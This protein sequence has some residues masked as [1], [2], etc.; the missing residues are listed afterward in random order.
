MYKPLDCIALRTVRYS[1]RNSILTAYT[2]QAGR[3]SLLIPSGGGRVA[4][5]L[6]ALLMPLG[7]FE[8]VADI[9]PN[10]EIHPIRDVKSMVPPPVA[11]PARATIALFIADFL[12]GLLKEQMSDPLLFSFI[13]SA[14]RRLADDR[15]GY[16]LQ[17]LSLLNF[18]I[19][20]LTRLTRFVGI[21]PD[22][23]THTPGSFLDL[24]DGVFRPMPPPHRNYLPAG[25][26]AAAAWLGRI[27]FRNLG[28]FKL[29]RL[30]RNIATDRILTYYRTHYPSSAGESALAILRMLA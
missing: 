14:L 7:R 18:H 28:L 29:D 5:R 24:E 3:L 27:N 2:R 19:C 21:E 30:E 8:C 12:G 13:D 6:R 20:F 11:D 1:D 25:E 9:R 22:W 4:T 15:P 26:S 10:R 16:R 17:G 23:A